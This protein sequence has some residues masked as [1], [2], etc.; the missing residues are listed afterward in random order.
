MP[1]HIDFIF[2]TGN[3]GRA[4]R[5]FPLRAAS[6]CQALDVLLC[7][8]TPLLFEIGFIA[9]TAALCGKGQAVALAWHS[10]RRLRQR[11]APNQ[12]S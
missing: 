8:I 3:S 2:A 10:V 1:L 4:M 12:P 6:G 11:S 9:A 5:R 7:E